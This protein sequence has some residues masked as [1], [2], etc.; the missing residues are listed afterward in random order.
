MYPYNITW[1]KKSHFKTL[2]TEI[3]HVI[4][5]ASNPGPAPPEE[6]GG[7]SAVPISAGPIAPI[8]NQWHVFYLL[9]V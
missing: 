3:L 9:L 5:N 8:R 2:M 4:Y 7:Y 1:E 6:W